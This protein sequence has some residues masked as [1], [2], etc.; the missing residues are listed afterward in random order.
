MGP[1]Q[2]ELS[3]CLRVWHVNGTLTFI[4]YKSEEVGTA[5]DHGSPGTHFKP[6]RLVLSHF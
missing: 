5:R 2:S 1:I 4:F 3:R 6:K